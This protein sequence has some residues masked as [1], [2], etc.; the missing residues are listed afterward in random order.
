MKITRIL[1]V[2][3]V[4]AA[5]GCGNRNEFKA[6][7][8]PAVTVQNPQVRD[9]T[10]Y[11]DFSGQTQAVEVVE[12][13]ARVKGFLKSVDFQAGEVVQEG[14]LLFTIEP[15]EYQAALA[16]A[17]SLLANAKANLSLAKNTYERKEKLFVQHAIS[18]LE[19]LESRAQQEAAD[20]QVREAAAAV[21]NAQLNLSY[22]RILA[23]ITGRISRELRTVGNLVGSGESTLLTTIVKDDPIYAYVTV[24]ERDL[25]PRLSQRMEEPGREALKTVKLE[26]ADKSVYPR[27]GAMDFLDNVFDAATG[28]IQARAVF[29]NPEHAL[30]SGLFVRVLI[31]QEKPGALLVPDLALQLDMAGNFVL[32][33]N[34]ENIVESRYVTPGDKVNGD[35][36]IEKGLS[37]GDRVIVNGIQRARPGIP[38]TPSEGEP[39]AV[40]G[41]DQESAPT[42]ASSETLP[43]D[44]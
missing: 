18:D 6:P 26:L 8:P 34:D 20:A 44:A 2:I 32:T 43:Q 10:T 9:V 11:L 19:Y 33:V 29:P 24:S 28:T 27:E 25:I 22:T 37:A 40:P 36:I 35:R 38:V 12:I 14:A 15:E 7:P 42:D 1:T 3:L 30:V 16:S 21:T 13:R 23:P 4:V 39:P 5:A 41:K 31:P 17:E